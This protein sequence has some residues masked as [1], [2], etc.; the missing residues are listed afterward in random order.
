[1][2]FGVGLLAGGFLAGAAGADCDLGG[3]EEF[4]S[5]CGL[6][7]LEDEAVGDAG[8]EGVDGVGAGGEEGHGVAVGVVDPP[9]GFGAVVVAGVVTGTGFVVGIETALDGEF[10]GHGWFLSWLG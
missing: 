7:D 9:E 2:G 6:E 3:V 5:F 4:G 1:L 10:G 8:D